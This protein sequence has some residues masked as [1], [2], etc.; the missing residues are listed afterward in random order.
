MIVK[1][2]YVKVK[3]GKKE[4]TLRNYIYD[5]YLKLFS[6]YQKAPYEMRGEITETNNT[7]LECCCIKLDTELEDYTNA[8]DSDFDIFIPLKNYELSGNESGT[9]T[10]YEYSSLMI[11][12]A[13]PIDLTEYDG[14]KI[15]A[16]GFC[17]IT[18]W[19]DVHPVYEL[20]ACLDT[21][22]YSIYVNAEQGIE[23]SRKDTIQ[24]NA[25]CD[26]YDYPLHLSPILERYSEQD[27]EHYGL[28]GRIRAVLYSVGFGNMRGKM[29]QEWIIGEEAIINEIDDFSY[30]V[31]MKNPTSV[32]IY[33]A[34]NMYPSSGL[35]PIQP[36]YKESIYPQENR[37]TSQNM[38]P[39]KAGYN[40]IIF[41]YRLYYNILDEIT[42]LDE[43]YTMSYA[44]TPKGI[45]I[46]TNKIERG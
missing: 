15:T 28:I 24:S 12:Y 2:E 31:A 30:G 32:P 21:S 11:N 26:G 23:I 20:Y 34:N 6:D 7:K 9:S 13:N 33:P 8:S 42:Y 27:D 39:M 46:A 3:S 25:V 16:I 4:Y 1:N 22:Y 37:Y 45:F 5:K 35:Y 41:K 44:Y 17:G 18:R 29:A 40:Y 19:R 14:K 36:E 43:Y 38:Y 10:I